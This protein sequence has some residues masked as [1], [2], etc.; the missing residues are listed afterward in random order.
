MRY[1]HV[2]LAATVVF[3]LMGTA[4]LW[5]QGVSTAAQA[6]GEVTPGGNGN[7][8]CASGTPEDEADCGLPTDTTNGGCNSNPIVTT[9]VSCN[10]TICGTV[11]SNG[12]TRDTDWWDLVLPI[13]DNVTVTATMETDIALFEIVDPVCPAVV[14]AQDQQPVCTQAQINFAGSAGSNWIFIA[15]QA[16]GGYACGTEYTMTVTCEVVPVELE[17]IETH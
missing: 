2:L 4:A 13:D 6:P 14:G 11:G 17:S 15:G 9:P 16:F 10:E 3:C 8:P 5:A 7:C 1:P 12:S